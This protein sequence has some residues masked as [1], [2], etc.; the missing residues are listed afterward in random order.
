ME[1]VNLSPGDKQGIVQA[2]WTSV[3]NGGA[4]L[5]LV[6][7]IIKTL[8]ET[9]AWRD[10]EVDGRPYHN[11]SFLQFITTKPLQGCGW[12]V[13]KIKALLAKDPDVEAMFHRATTGK[14][15]RPPKENGDIVTI[16]S[17]RGHSRA[18]VLDRLKRERPDLFDKV[19]A[20]ELSANAAAI[21]AGWRRQQTPL[22]RICKLLPKISDDEL[23]ELAAEIAAEIDRRLAHA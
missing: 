3:N 6:P 11:D 8:L 1:T 15:G 12:P 18:Y 20:G 19:V 17:E 23:E 5:E 21:E 10:R 16:K 7:K 13:E 9:E 14:K 4:A 2:L 22:E